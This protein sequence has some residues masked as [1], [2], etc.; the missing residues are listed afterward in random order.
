LYRDDLSALGP[1]PIVH[2]TIIPKRV[3]DA[4]IV[5]VDD[6]VYT[7][8]TVRAALD[9]CLTLDG[10]RLYNSAYS[11]TEGIVSFHSTRLHWKNVPTSKKEVIEVHVE[12][13]DGETPSTSWKSRLTG[14]TTTLGTHVPLKSV[15]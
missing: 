4:I 9:A 5:L 13:I 8:R 6:V 14:R 11:L 15:P 12:E 7:G 1:N 3:D 10:Q 2:Q